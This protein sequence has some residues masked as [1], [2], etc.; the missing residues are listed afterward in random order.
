MSDESDRRFHA[1]F[2][3]SYEFLGLLS[4]DGKLLKANRT[5]LAI[6]DVEENDVAGKPFWETP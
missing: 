5:A 4:I 6:G 3:Q 2:D 1:V